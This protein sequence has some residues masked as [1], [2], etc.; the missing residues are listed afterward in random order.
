M[1]LLSEK[2]ITTLLRVERQIADKVGLGELANSKEVRDFSKT[3]SIERVAQTI[4][5]T[6]PSE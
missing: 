5:E 2:E 1:L 3:M 4:K 6:L